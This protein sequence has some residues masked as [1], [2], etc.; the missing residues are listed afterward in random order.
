MSAAALAVSAGLVA[1]LLARLDAARTLEL[2]R[3]A[4]TAWLALAAAV[5]LTNPFLMV[6]RWR[7]VLRAQAGQSVAGNAAGA[8]R[9]GL[10]FSVALRAVLIANVLNS[11][12]PSKAGDLAKA[13]YLKRHGGLT[14]GLGSVLLERSVDFLVLGAL[15]MAGYG[16]SRVAWGLW[17]GAA[18]VA[19]VAGVFALML[20]VP[21]E[22][23]GLPIPGRARAAA[24]EFG[25]LWRGW[26]VHPAAI[27]Q[28]VGGS[29]GVW[30]SNGLIVFA[31]IRAFG[32]PLPLSFAFSV[33]PTAILAGLVPATVSGVGTRDAAFVFLLGARM[34]VEEATLVAL[35]YTVIGYWLLSLI[36]L[37]VVW[38]ELRRNR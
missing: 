35:G 32:P 2:L 1:W 30:L 15:S 25:A 22:R 29:L 26:I 13:L 28:T 20:A 8:A 19:G 18:L 5:V 17:T 23:L 11:V 33:Y 24:V 9:G 10:P 34:S 6:V 16:I 36:S 21:L 7:G 31:L 14:R 12:L 3:R 27:A 37:P 4:D 38:W